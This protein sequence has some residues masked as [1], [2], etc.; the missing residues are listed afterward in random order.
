MNKDINRIEFDPGKTFIGFEAIPLSDFFQNP[1]ELLCTPHKDNFYNILF[2][3]AGEGV[4]SVDFKDHPFDAGT[5][6]T[7]SPNQIQQHH[8]PFRA[9]GFLLVFTQEFIVKYFDSKEVFRRLQIFDDAFQNPVIQLDESGKSDILHG[10]KKLYDQQSGVEKDEFTVGILRSGLNMMLL[11]L[12]RYKRKSNVLAQ[13]NVYFQE[14]IV[15]KNLVEQKAASSRSVL[16]YATELLISTKKL[17][18]ICQ[19]VAR[20][21]AKEVIDDI[22]I[23][24]IKRDLLLTQSAKQST[25]NFGFDEPSNFVK[26]FKKNTGKTPY[27]FIQEQGA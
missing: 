11:M 27:A 21:T 12:E 22:A 6:F 5:I 10:V 20:K 2:I 16:D 23:L 8:L 3:E 1:A 19:N 7:I 18:Y 15:F 26:Y 24:Q 13:K 25:Y 9:S 17:N 4:L 14:F